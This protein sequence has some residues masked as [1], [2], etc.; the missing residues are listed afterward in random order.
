[1]LRIEWWRMDRSRGRLIAPMLVLALAVLRAPQAL[2]D[3]GHPTGG[4]EREV[5]VVN[6][7]KRTINELYISPVTSGEWGADR[8][9]DG[10]IAPGGARRVRLAP[11]SDCKVDVQ[12]VY[13]DASR[14]E[15]HGADICR[16]R[17]LAFD[18]SQAV[19]PAGLNAGA[20]PVVIVNEAARPI[21][22]V[23]ISPADSGDW[24]DDLLGQHS[25]STGERTTLT[26]HGSCLADVRIVYD[27]RSAEERRNVDV[28]TLHGVD[29]R[30]GWTTL[31]LLAPLPSSRRGPL[32]S[33]GSAPPG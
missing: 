17:Q 16:E 31:D 21:Q 18:G 25:L 4:G 22:Q 33:P 6:H 28:C 3:P 7:A 27:N 19:L 20:H 10:T 30:P 5:S 23:L 29:I 32:P 14:E 1:M 11:G 24:G 2:A 13:D 12:V 9:G 8:L 26:Y 15:R